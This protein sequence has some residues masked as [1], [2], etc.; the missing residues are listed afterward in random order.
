[1]ASKGKA[2]F[3]K[4]IGDAVASLDELDEATPA[5]E[6][7][8]KLE[9]APTALLNMTAEI[10]EMREQ[11]SNLEAENK[12]LKE[13]LQASSLLPLEKLVKSPYQDAAFDEARVENLVANLKENPL[14]TPITVRLAKTPGFYEILSGHNRVEAYRR[15]GF[16]AIPAFI[17]DRTDDEAERLVFYDNLLAPALSDF[18][19]YRWF[20][21]RR[22]THNLTLRQLSQESGIS[23]TNLFRLF[24][25]EKLPEATLEA[26]E[27]K[28]IDLTAGQAE[29]LSKYAESHPDIVH[30]AALLLSSGKLKA[31]N[32]PGVLALMISRSTEAQGKSTKGASLSSSSYKIWA[33]ER[34][35]G[36]LY[37]SHEQVRYRPPKDGAIDE[38]LKKKLVAAMEKTIQEHFGCGETH[39][40]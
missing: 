39:S 1:M 31:S 2:F 10:R 7:K 12:E 20:S 4:V 29:T 8:A 6:R 25:F 22:R 27:D 15:L 17:V 23:S 34:P 32:L 3:S 11:I 19:K 36:S 24:S 21:R 14:N 28:S 5:S 38:E 40:E 16:E 13:H 35:A 33:G 9:P 18:E 26:L 30:E 37:V